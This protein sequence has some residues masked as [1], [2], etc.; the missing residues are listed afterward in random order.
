MLSLMKKL[1]NLIE[2]FEKQK[3]SVIKEKDNI[4][5]LVIYLHTKNFV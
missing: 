5:Y 4:F 3:Q 2:P 1:L